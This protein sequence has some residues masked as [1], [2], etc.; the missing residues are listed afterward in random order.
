MLAEDEPLGFT[1]HHQKEEKTLM[2]V[3]H[4]FVPVLMSKRPNN[5]HC[6]NFQVA[7]RPTQEISLI[8][9]YIIEGC[10]FNEITR[11]FRQTATPHLFGSLSDMHVCEQPIDR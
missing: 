2:S 6:G 1:D 7:F 5:R 9:D 3:G 4:H 10:F 11:L 8:A